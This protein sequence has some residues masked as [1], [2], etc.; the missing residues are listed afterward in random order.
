M[1]LSVLVV[2]CLTFGVSMVG[3][4]LPSRAAV[5]REGVMES[6]ALEERHVLERG[7]VQ[8]DAHDYEH[9]EDRDPDA[10]DVTVPAD[11]CVAAIAA[12]W[13]HQWGRRLSIREGA[14]VLS[15]HA[16]PD[17]RVLHTQWCSPPGGTQRLTVRLERGG[18]D[19]YGRE[20]QTDGSAHVAVYRAPASSVGG[21]RAIDRGSIP[22]AVL[23]ARPEV[24]EAAEASRPSGRLLAALTIE[25]FAARL[26]PEDAST[27]APLYVG[28]RNG[29]SRVVN[30]RLTPLPL[31]TPPAWRPGTAHTQEALR[32]AHAPTE[33]PT[34]THP[35]V[36]M[37]RDGMVRVLAIVDGARLGVACA[38]IQL[39]RMRYGFEVEVQRSEATQTLFEPLPHRENLAGDRLCASQGAVVYVVPTTDR[40]PYT[41]RIFEADAGG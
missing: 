31:E 14:R 18:G 41:L 22:D 25:P 40:A 30:P 20:G 24:M 23:A 26:I 10:F 33:H 15:E 13:G 35:A 5:P 16:D 12:T 7:F 29:S 11:T 19:V 21:F 36:R 37:G 39:V 6:Y 4:T 2:P 9:A 34:E 1:A 8:V 32:A 17:G 3:A 27:Y 38:R 28:A